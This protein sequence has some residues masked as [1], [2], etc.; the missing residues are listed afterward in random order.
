MIVEATAP[1]DVNDNTTDPTVQALLKPSVPITQTDNTANPMRQA[2]GNLFAI[3]ANLMGSET[4]G[5]NEPGEN[6]Q[7]N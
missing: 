2:P 3:A 7:V 4:T 6:S 5:G 1:Q